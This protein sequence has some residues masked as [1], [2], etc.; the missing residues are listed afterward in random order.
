MD[1]TKLLRAWVLGGD[2]RYPWAVKSLRES[3][4]PVKTWGVMGMKNDVE[5]LTE[6][7]QGA[8]LVLLPM[9]PF[10]DK[11]LRIGEEETV[12]ALLPYMLEKGAVLIGGDF[13]TETEAWLQS[14]GVFC[15]NFLELE[16]YQMANA[17]VTAEGAVYLTLRELQ[18][19]LYGA[20]V[21]VI[22]WGR[23]GRF[24]AEKLKALGANV[25]VTAR[26]EGQWKEIESLGF[27]P[28]ETG[29]Y[30]HGLCDYDAVLNTVPAPVM[31]TEQAANLKQECV[32]I[33]LASLPGGFAPEIQEM[34]EVVMA[35]GLP[36]QT[37]PKSAGEN[38]AAAVWACLTGEGRTLE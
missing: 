36:G 7:L 19:T 12:A 13:P 37:A 25:T 15:V 9:R 35:Q 28:E 23:I 26:R 11:S 30:H 22:G 10:Q 2:K 33:E 31:H 27:R 8:N 29:V 20:E 24:L 18:R 38:L 6:A 4:L 1:D 14:Q 21:L 16:S 34:R 3:G 5:H 17:A 32:L